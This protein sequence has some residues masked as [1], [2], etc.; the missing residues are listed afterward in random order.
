M[1]GILIALDFLGLP[2]L[3]AFPVG[4]LEELPVPRL[5]E[6]PVSRLEE[7]PVPRLE[8]LLVPRLEE[9]P[10][11]RLDELAELR[12]PLEYSSS[13]SSS[14]GRFL[15]FPLLV[16]PDLDVSADP[17][18][19]DRPPLPTPSSSSVSEVLLTFCLNSKGSNVLSQLTRTCVN[20]PRS[21]DLPLTLE[22]A[23]MTSLDWAPETSFA[24]ASPVSR[25]AL[26]A[27]AA[28]TASFAPALASCLRFLSAFR[29]AASTFSMSFFP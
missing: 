1:G 5:E 14:A 19:P 11:P 26:V 20:P 15:P 3:D 24:S 9:L 21:S 13:A 12:F 16:L 4:C 6:L 18:S 27:S 7:L 28:S 8:E 10:L 2:E 29:R 17:I 25:M 22:S 23:S